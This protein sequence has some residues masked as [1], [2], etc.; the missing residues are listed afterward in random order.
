MPRDDWP[1][2]DLIAYWS[3]MEAREVNPTRLAA[4]LRSGVPL[5]QAERHF[6][7]DLIEGKINPRKPRPTKFGEVKTALK[8][9]AIVQAVLYHEAIHPKRQR[10]TIIPDVGKFYGVSPRFV[11]KLLS[12]FD[13]KQ[14]Q[15]IRQSALAFAEWQ[16]TIAHK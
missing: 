3:V 14:L 5:S 9:Y 1:T 12:E 13:P 7:A 10:K 6:L 2:T 15:L 8:R 4:R 11:F 16:S